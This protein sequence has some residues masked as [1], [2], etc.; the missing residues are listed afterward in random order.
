MPDRTLGVGM[1][2]EGR[3]TLEESG[4]VPMWPFLERSLEASLDAFTRF[5]AGTEFPVLSSWSN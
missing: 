3:F 4:Y 5:W 2:D 1:E